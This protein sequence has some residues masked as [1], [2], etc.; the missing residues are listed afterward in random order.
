M[1]GLHHAFDPSHLGSTL[2]FCIFWVFSKPDILN[3]AGVCCRPRDSHSLLALL[4]QKHI[5][6]FANKYA[7]RVYT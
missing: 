7:L 4:W 3:E 6:M 2:F 1:Q 5:K